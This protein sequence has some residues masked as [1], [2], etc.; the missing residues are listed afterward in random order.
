MLFWHF[1]TTILSISQSCHCA[2]PLSVHVF[3]KRPE[4]TGGTRRA[5]F[6]STSSTKLRCFSSQHQ[7]IPGNFTRSCWGTL[8][9]SSRVSRSR[10]GWLT[11]AQGTLGLL[12]R[13]STIWR[14]GCLDKESIG[15]WRRAVTV[16]LTR[17]SGQRFVTERSPAFLRN[18]HIP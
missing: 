9:S 4:R 6:E 8:R 5:Y 18:T 17:L 15:R 1:T 16:P 10:T 7:R 11:C 2:T 13:K 3:E 14:R 12:R